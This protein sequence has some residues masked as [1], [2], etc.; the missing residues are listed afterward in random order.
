MDKLKIRNQQDRIVDSYFQQ[1][2]PQLEV[3]H[4]VQDQ[5]KL[6]FRRIRISKRRNHL[7]IYLGRL[8]VS[9]FDFDSESAD[10]GV[11]RKVVTIQKLAIRENLSI[12]TGMPQDILD[13]PSKYKYDNFC[14][15][16]V[17]TRHIKDDSQQEL[18]IKVNLQPLKLK[19][20]KELLNFL[21]IF[22]EGL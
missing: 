5:P 12:Q 9:V 21:T 11:D 7:Q 8:R 18:S 16:V 3:S 22:I 4:F 13:L 10:V 6:S 19:I 2:K 1:K 14:E 15:L 20:R 17:S